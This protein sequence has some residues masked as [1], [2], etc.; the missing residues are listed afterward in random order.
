MREVTDAVVELIRDDTLGGRVMVMWREEQ[1]RLI[2]PDR[3]E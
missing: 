2:D 1:R 3:R